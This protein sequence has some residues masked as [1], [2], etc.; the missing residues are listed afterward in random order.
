[1]SKGR[2]SSLTGAGPLLNFSST[3]KR[4][5]SANALKPDQEELDGKAYT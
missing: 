3:A 2:A 4:V 1:M 5:G